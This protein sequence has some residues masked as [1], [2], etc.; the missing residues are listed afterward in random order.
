MLSCLSGVL[1]SAAISQRRNLFSD[2]VTQDVL[3]P[4]ESATWEREQESQERE[5]KIV[6][7]QLAIINVANKAQLKTEVIRAKATQDRKAH[8]EKLEMIQARKAAEA[9]QENLEKNKA[10]LMKAAAPC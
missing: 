9:F 7:Q 8:S 10:V 1:S 3:F 5:A 2:T 4:R 6:D